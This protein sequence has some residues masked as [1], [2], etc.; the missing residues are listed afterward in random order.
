MFRTRRAVSLRLRFTFEFPVFTF[1]FGIPPLCPSKLWAKRVFRGMTECH[2]VPS[3][4]RKGPL[5]KVLNIL[6][7]PLRGALSSA[8]R[9]KLPCATLGKAKRRGYVKKNGERM[10]GETYPLRSFAPRPPDSEGQSS[11][12][13]ET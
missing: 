12:V 7:C 3:E 11:G 9:G 4:G 8:T 2:S 1:P 6:S 5:E 13:P 10:S